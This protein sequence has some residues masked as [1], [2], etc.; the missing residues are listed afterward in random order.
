[1]PICSKVGVSPISV[2]E[3]PMRISVETMMGLRPTRSPKCAKNTPPIGRAANPT[4]NTPNPAM[5]PASGLS[6]GKNRALNATGVR[7]P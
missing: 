5:V 2:V 4:A 3:A 6:D 7:K 1:M